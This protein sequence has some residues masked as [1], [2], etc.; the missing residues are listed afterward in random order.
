ML[1]IIRHS[2]ID[3]ATNLRQL[4]DLSETSLGYSHHIHN[5]P[6]LTRW[7][8]GGSGKMCEEELCLKIEFGMNY[9]SWG[10]G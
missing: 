9:A 4:C 6:T 7:R 10:D 3:D 5:L 1:H 2:S 8:V